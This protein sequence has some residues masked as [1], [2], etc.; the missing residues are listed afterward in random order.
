M[1]VWDYEV[2]SYSSV[3]KKKKVL[4]ILPNKKEY[5]LNEI[6]PVLAT[7]GTKW[8]FCAKIPSPRLATNRELARWLAQG[9]GEWRNINIEM[10]TSSDYIYCCDESNETLTDVINVRKWSDDEWHEPT[11]DYMGLEAK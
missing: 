7:D 1:F 3:S 8:N 5:R 2:G 9:N 10:S 4:A 11:A 6:K